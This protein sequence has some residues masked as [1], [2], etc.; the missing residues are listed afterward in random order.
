MT[1]D[2]LKDYV[3]G[4]YEGKLTPLDTGRF[5]LWFEVKAGDLVEVA[6]SLRDD[7]QLK[8]D[9]LCNIGGVDTTERFEAVYSLAST[10]HKHRIDL[11]VVMSHDAPEV[12]SVQQVWPGANWFEREMWELYGINVKNHD[13]L[14]RFLLPDEWDQGHPMRK[15]WDAP[16]FIR[17]P[18]PGQ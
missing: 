10:V 13:N 6:Q 2:A 3:A 8:F 12:D 5:D 17:M 4:H 16:D 11:K 18:E 9:F 7:E 15:D 1:K 14:T